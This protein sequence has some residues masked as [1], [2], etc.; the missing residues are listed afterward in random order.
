MKW[1]GKRISFV[2][3]K[4]KTTIVIYPEEATFLKGLMGAWMFMWLIAGATVI[5]SFTAFDFTDQEV[6]ILVVFL[7]FWFYYSIRVVSS[8][9]WL[10]WGKELIKID[11]VAIT[12]K[13]SIRK[14]GKAIPYYIENVK[15]MRMDVPNDNSL[16]SVWEKSI[17]TKGGERFEFDYMGKIIRFGKKLNRKDAELL[18]KLMTK[19]V[20]GYQKSL[21]D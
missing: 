7:S 17:W 1:I 9:S 5:W 19:R 6:I 2:D 12:Y 10:M 18:F 16:Q 8:W 11:K 14:Y 15:E 21:K 4:T 3:D 13:K 20:E